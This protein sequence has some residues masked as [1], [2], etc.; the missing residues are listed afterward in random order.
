VIGLLD[1]GLAKELPPGFGA[2]SPSW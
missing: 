2:A 1:F